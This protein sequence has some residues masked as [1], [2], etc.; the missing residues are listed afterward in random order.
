MLRWAFRQKQSTGLFLLSAPFGSS[1]VL[2]QNIKKTA[3]K[4]GLFYMAESTG[5][6]PVHGFKTMTD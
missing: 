4:D 5:L 3:Q 1:P 6:E 2:N